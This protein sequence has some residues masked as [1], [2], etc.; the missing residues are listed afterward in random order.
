MINYLTWDLWNL[1]EHLKLIIIS[2]QK[3][4]PNDWM[5]DD[6]ASW[7]EE[8]TATMRPKESNYVSLVEERE[9]AQNVGTTMMRLLRVKECLLPHDVRKV[10][11]ITTCRAVYQVFT[12]IH[13]KKMLICCCCRL[14]TLS[15][16]PLP[17]LSL[18]RCRHSLTKNSN[19]I[20]EKHDEILIADSVKTC[21]GRVGRKNIHW[22]MFEIIGRL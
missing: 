11:H 1:S 8:I 3:K 2:A 20:S 21:S 14:L 16:S 5:N 17:F 12:Q 19:V 9:K 10:H 7:A 22:R 4:K 6:P 13:N 15:T 18:R